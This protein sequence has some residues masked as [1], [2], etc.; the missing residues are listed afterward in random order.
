MLATYPQFSPQSLMGSPYGTSPFV[1]P[2]LQAGN[3][4]GYQPGLGGFGQPGQSFGNQFVQSQVP[5]Q[6]QGQV[7]GHVAYAL[8]QQL[9]VG[10]AQLAHQISIQSVVSQQI[11]AAL[12]QLT[13]QIQGLTSGMPGVGVGQ[14]YS[15]A[16]G[17]QPFIGG[18]PAWQQAWGGQR[19]QTIQ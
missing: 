19:T 10:L 13:Q 11:G 16:F 12:Q 2:G 5:W 14:P 6:G 9:V 1:P 3:S 15:Q 17:Q 7:Q 4:F 18:Q 8:A